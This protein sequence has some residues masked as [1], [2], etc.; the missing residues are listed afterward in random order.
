MAAT[1]PPGVT[2]LSSFLQ[3]ISTTSRFAKSAAAMGS[4]RSFQADV[5]LVDDDD[6]EQAGKCTPPPEY[7][8]PETMTVVADDDTAR[9]KYANQGH[10]LL[11]LSLTES[12]GEGA[13]SV[14]AASAPLDT[15]FSR[16]LYI[17]SLTYLLHGLPPDLS[18]A[19][20]AALRDSLPPS[21][22]DPAV[23][24]R[25]D[26]NAVVDSRIEALIVQLIRGVAVAVKKSA[27]HVRYAVNVGMRYERRYRVTERALD[28]GKEA[29]VLAGQ[30]GLGKWVGGVMG[31]VGVGLGEGVRV[32]LEEELKQRDQAAVDSRR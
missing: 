21:L 8:T 30:S 29:L 12:G 19:E 3:A 1:P 23:P 13:G 7:E 9:R 5:V 4:G 2:A 22:L 17:H 11:T 24:R 27:P 6:N 26:G 16:D 25:P 10:H 32:L 28:V 31:A 14:K 18:P 15:L 20:A